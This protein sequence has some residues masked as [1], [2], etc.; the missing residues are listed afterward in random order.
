MT[1][2]RTTLIE[3]TVSRKLKAFGAAAAVLFVGAALLGST[4]QAKAEHFVIDCP[5]HMEV[6]VPAHWAPGPAIWI[7]A[8][9]E[10]NGFD[11]IVHPGHFVAGPWIWIPEVDRFVP[12]VGH[13]DPD[14]YVAPY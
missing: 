8:R 14:V 5:A 12:A 13:W 6:D 2:N 3:Y 11:W 10:F 4:T 9:S 1:I 7:P